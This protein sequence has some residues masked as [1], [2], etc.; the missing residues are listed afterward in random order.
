MYGVEEQRSVAML[1]EFCP[2]IPEEITLP[3]GCIVVEPCVWTA[4][5]RSKISSA[6]R[7]LPGRMVPCAT[8]SARSAA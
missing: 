5:A 7:W 6:R 8:L 2:N 1:K 4:H 3:H